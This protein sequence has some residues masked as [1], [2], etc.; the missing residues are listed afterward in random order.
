M[1]TLQLMCIVGFGV[2]MGHFIACMRGGEDAGEMKVG[3]G[4]AGMFAFLAILAQHWKTP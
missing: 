4:G 3:I 2:C 1:M